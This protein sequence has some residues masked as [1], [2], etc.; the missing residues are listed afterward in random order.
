MRELAPYLAMLRRYRA[1]LGLGA[2]LMF[3]TAASGIGLLALSGWFITATAVTGAL[4]AAGIAATLNI[5]IPGGGIRAFAVTRTA[6]RYFERLVNHDTVLRLLS[7]LRGGVFRTLAGLPATEMTKLR[8]GELLNRLTN[9]I[10][11]LDGLFLRSL[12]PTLIAGLSVVLVTLL[13]MIGSIRVGL[14]TGMTL[15]GFGVL[16]LMLAWR[17]GCITTDALAKASAELRAGVIDHLQGLA[18][19]K[20]FGSLAQHRQRLL[21]SADHAQRL[22]STMNARMAAGEAAIT[23]GVHLAAALVLLTALA[24]YGSGETTGA[25]AVMMPLAVMALLEPLGV[26]PGAG[27]HLARARASATRLQQDMPVPPVGAATSVKH[28]A[29]PATDTR[30]VSV[31]MDN[32]TLTRGAGDKVLSGLSL[33]IAP[34]E[35]IGILGRSGIGKSSI[36][37]LLSQ[38]IA[39]DSGAIEIDHQPIEAIPEA[40]LYQRLAYLTQQTDLFSSS[41]AGNLRIAKRDASHEEIWGVLQA[42]ALDEFVAGCEQGLDTW[43]GESGTELSAGQARRLAL[44]RLMLRDPDLVILD[45]PFAGLDNVTA[46]HVAR[47]LSTWRRGRTTILLGHDREALPIADR[48]LTLRSGQLA[49]D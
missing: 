6:A 35:C 41:I 33:N 7:D 31:T 15:A 28:R 18:E 45:E 11:R 13:L 23:G 17:H 19:L 9:D 38:Q 8:G 4:L 34:G 12:A 44:A 48:W 5:Y 49:L 14:A 36:A 20:A 43:I 2:L 16:I 46:Q 24:L 22:E 32:V 42:V 10:D 27:W 29:S 37:A 26:L 40:H 21:A 3:I 47:H 25:I 39:A 30:G 1:R